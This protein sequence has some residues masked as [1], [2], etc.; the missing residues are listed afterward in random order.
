MPV[1]IKGIHLDSGR[2]VVCVPVTD[3]D[4]LMICS[5]VNDAVKAGYQMVEWR[6]DFYQD[7]MDKDELANL[8]MYLRSITKNTILLVT[9]RTVKEGGQA[10]LSEQ[11]MT[12]LLYRIAESH[13]ADIID[14][15]YCGYSDPAAVISGLHD[16]G[17]L[18]IAS[19]HNFQMTYDE[20]E[21]LKRLDEMLTADPDIVKIALMPQSP[22]DTAVLLKATA[23]F[24]EKEPFVPLITMSMGKTGLISRLSGEIFGSCVTFGSMSEASAPGQIPADELQKELDFLH[25]KLS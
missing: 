6:A 5:H 24:H 7:L 1:I 12:Q 3:D 11:E 16:R 23:E 25:E 13:C 21:I 9:I 17:A 2:P 14:A 10:D 19:H 8:L 20:N 15:E 18:V 22:A 4:K